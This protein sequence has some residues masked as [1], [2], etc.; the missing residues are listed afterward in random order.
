MNVPFGLDHPLIAVHDIDALRQ[1]LISLGFA[2]TPVG[3]HPWGTSTSLAMF[4]GCLLEIMGVY[5]A[6]LTSAH[7]A[8]DFRFGRHVHAHLQKR[9]GIALTALHSLD[10]GRDA[11]RAE[12]AGWKVAG[13]LEFGRDVTL[14]DGRAGRTK[15]S[16]ALIPNP[17][18]PRLSFFLC[19]QHRPDLI[20]VP[21]WMQHP[22]SVSGYAG[23][24]VMAGPE[25]TAAISRHLS[26][27]YGAPEAIEGG[28]A[29]DTGNG[30]LR[31]LT[32]AAIET[33]YGA[34]SPALGTQAAPAIVALDLVYE[35]E[36]RLA[37]CLDA[38]GLAYR[39]DGVR[40][41][42]SDAALTGNTV[43]AFGPRHGA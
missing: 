3:R 18:W 19:Q 11:E 42:L 12:R 2:M 39:Q 26:T 21:E 24:S 16:L 28:V 37:A 13:R 40:Y 38:S 30:A 27:I 1:R 8:G 17:N 20:Y 6:S 41:W 7:P 33:R 10:A 29:F 31:V 36:A 14:P 23:S 35:D 34:L 25:D 22:N 9:E 32:P 15:T 5:D 43:L 4:H